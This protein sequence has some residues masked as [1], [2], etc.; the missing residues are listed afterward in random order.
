M[1]IIDASNTKHMQQGTI[2]K[3]HTLVISDSWLR[4]KRQIE[5]IRIE[6]KDTDGDWKVG[7]SEWEH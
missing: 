7:V 6:A 2:T 4:P 1:L 5:R 3:Y